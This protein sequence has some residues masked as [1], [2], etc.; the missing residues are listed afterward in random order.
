MNEQFTVAEYGQKAD[1]SPAFRAIKSGSQ[2]IA[3]MGD[4][5]GRICRL[6]AA[7]PDLL[8]ALKDVRDNAK[9]DSPA[10]W[11]RVDAAIAKAEGT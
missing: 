2:T 7:A 5:D 9:D 4:T 1:A 3:N 6:F 11:M 10:M 8:A